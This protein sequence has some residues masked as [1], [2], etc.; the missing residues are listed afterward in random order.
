MQPLMMTGNSSNSDYPESVVLE[1][2]AT[3]RVSKKTPSKVKTP[4]KLKTPSK[5]KTPSKLKTPSK[6]KTPSRLKTPTKSKTPTSAGKS[7]RT[8]RVVS[9]KGKNKSKVN[10]RTT[11]VR[12]TPLLGSK[13]IGDGKKS[14]EMVK[15][16]S[17]TPARR[18]RRNQISSDSDSDDSSPKR[19]RKRWWK[20][21]SPV[22][23]QNRGSTPKQS[24][25]LIAASMK[26]PPNPR[27]PAT[28][29]TPWS[30]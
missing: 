15:P 13:A 11:G 29:S 7:K 24:K 12:L 25:I 18:K 6:V 21:S 27:R 20:R 4:S 8:S 5:V 28:R 10:K 2:S 17:V 19:R 30:A 16:I 26:T 9:T 3:P 1:S 23:P 14:K 22:Q